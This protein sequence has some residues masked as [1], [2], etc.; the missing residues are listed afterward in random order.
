MRAVRVCPPEYKA[1][2]R[3]RLH[4]GLHKADLLGLFVSV[5]FTPGD[6]LEKPLFS[7]SLSLN[8]PT[9]QKVCWGACSG[10]H[11]SSTQLTEALQSWQSAALPADRVLTFGVGVHALEN[12]ASAD[13]GSHDGAQPCLC[14]HNVSS[15]TGSL[16]CTCSQAPTAQHSAC[17]SVVCSARHHSTAAGAL[18]SDQGRCRTNTPWLLHVPRPQTSFRPAHARVPVDAMPGEA[19]PSATPTSSGDKSSPAPCSLGRC[20]STHKEAQDVGGTHR[21]RQHRR[22]RA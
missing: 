14:Q 3:S 15:S 9:W 13:D 16:R 8:R 1:D 19:K 2:S 17:N 10:W 12:L 7:V 5:A 6:M 18:A 21:V 4:P 22:Q 11:G 20:T